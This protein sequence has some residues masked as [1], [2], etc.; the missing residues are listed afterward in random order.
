MAPGPTPEVYVPPAKPSL[1]NLTKDFGKISKTQN[2]VLRALSQPHIEAY[3]DV[4]ERGLTMSL[5]SIPPVQFALPDNTKVALRVL[6]G[7][8]TA[9]RVPM[10]NVGATDARVFPSEARTGL[11]DYTGQLVA[12]FA[13][14]VNGATC[15]AMD[16]S[17]GEVPVMV[18]SKLCHLH[19]LSPAELVRRGETDSEFGGYFIIRGQ[20]RLLRLQVATRRNYPVCLTRTSYKSY[21]SLF[22]EH[23]VQMRCMTDDHSLAMNVMHFLSNGSAKFIFRYRKERFC[24]S[25][26]L[27]IRALMDITDRDIY[28]RLTEPG[29][30]DYYRNCIATMLRDV[31]SEV[32]TPLTSQ[33]SVRRY[34]GAMYRGK[35]LGRV[36]DWE[37]D[38]AVCDALLHDTVLIHLNSGEDKVNVLCFMIRK[39]F[40]YVRKEC[41][42]ESADN[43][44]LWEAQQG[45]YIYQQVIKNKVQM[46]CSNFR[47]VM[48]KR[49]NKNPTEYNITEMEVAH[50]FKQLNPIGAMVRSFVSTGNIPALPNI[51]CSDNVGLSVPAEKISYTRYMSHFRTIHRGSF[52]STMRTTA[53]RQ[54]LPEAW[55]FICPV[56][57]P[58]GAPCGLLNHLT[59]TCH[60]TA[61]QPDRAAITATVT[62]LG[63]TPVTQPR[64]AKQCYTV[65]LDGAVIGF[66]SH[67]AAPRLVNKL[68]HM[69]CHGEV[70]Q[71]LEVALIPARGPGG[72]YPALYLYSS[73]ARLMRPVLNLACQKVEYIGTLEQ[74][75]M[76]VAVNLREVPTESLALYSHAELADT[77]LLSSLGLLVPLSDLNQSPRNMYQCQMSKQTMGTPRH[78]W[79]ACSENKLY[80]LQTPHAPLFRP[81]HHDALAMDDFGQGTNAIVAVISY[82]GYDMEDAM[83]INKH[84]QERGLA[85][86]FIYKMRAL[87]LRDHN[88]QNAPVV[89]VFRR[90]DAHAERLSDYLDEDGIPHVGIL[91]EKDSP[92]S[93]SYSLEEDKFHVTRYMDEEPARVDSVKLLGDPGGSEIL[94]VVMLILRVERKPTVGDKFASRA[95]QK[96]ICSRLHATE[97]LPW[98]ESGLVP[99]I[100][101]NPHGFPSRMTIAMMVECMAG[102][103]GAVNGHCYDATP[104]RFSEDSTAI[105]YFGQVLERAGYNYYG[106]ET[107]YSGITG[108]ELEAKIFFGVIHYQR[109][110]HMVSDKW[111][112]RST[113]PVNCVT[114]QPVKGRKKG[115]GVRFGEMERDGVMAHGTTLIVQDRLFSCSDKAEMHVCSSCGSLLSPVVELQAQRSRGPR[116]GG[117]G[118]RPVCT[119]C[120]STR[121]VVTVHLP[122]MVLHLAIQLAAMNVKLN[123]KVKE[124]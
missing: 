37:P 65:L 58:D 21:G 28:R 39:L 91:L 51:I 57:T 95:G 62:A 45:S 97:D 20:E 50:C 75:Y 67:A 23:A 117:T 115:G 17:L 118:R 68:R 46:F 104:F 8:I 34:L 83:I 101:F 40:A 66:V 114:R 36:P 56:H 70:Y 73:D 79:P 94:Q 100:I 108:T 72:Q 15:I 38:E 103:A 89:K 35:L 3:N 80:R 18:G 26:I 112:V 113:G 82:T 63:V 121:D 64:P 111:Q 42:Q 60:V 48:V 1:E 78:N 99:D 105:D 69:K 30:S 61:G 5:A 43:P 27:V 107:M 7:R 71:Y 32:A 92:M 14:S 110:R 11:R 54:M 98:T 16:R 12:H 124:Q 47:L 81:T 44:M 74:V 59:T 90:D 106:T 96:G 2:K 19:G 9:P 120:D 53:V 87:D 29:D 33:L 119:V 76:N 88:R 13:V 77:S 84:A 22:T 86:G 109:L 93:C 10:S 116:S 52:F 55:G 85:C 4:V 6:G 102:K 123:V 31:Q 41:A 25:P 122:Y 49:Y 24:I